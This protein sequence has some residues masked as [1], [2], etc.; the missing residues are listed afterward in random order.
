VSDTVTPEQRSLNMSRIRSRDTRPEKSVRSLLHRQGFRF[1]KNV[2]NLPGKPD[3]VL[4]KYN[5]IIFVH[6]CFWHQHEGCVRAV[7][8]KA[9]S[10]YWLPKLNGNVMRDKKHM[11]GLVQLNW[12][13]IVVWEC[14]IN[15]LNA[16]TERLNYLL[17]K[18]NNLRG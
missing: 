12:N 15:N 4:P 17:K 18:D 3:I 5:T 16:L 6:G 1:K 8:P 10:E 7:R 14:E 11:A 2:K 13:V 9:N